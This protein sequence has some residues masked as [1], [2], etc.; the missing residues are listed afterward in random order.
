M[1]ELV[2]EHMSVLLHCLNPS[3]IH[4]DSRGVDIDHPTL[5]GGIIKELEAIF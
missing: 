2:T 3:E 1:Y 4:P 5:E